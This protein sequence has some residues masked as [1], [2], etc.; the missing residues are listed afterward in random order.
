[1]GQGPSPDEGCHGESV[2][3]RLQCALVLDQSAFE[4]GVSSKHDVVQHDN[5]SDFIAGE[6][7]AHMAVDGFP[8]TLLNIHGSS[9]PLELKAGM[10]SGTL[11]AL[12]WA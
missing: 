11:D 5:G 6:V 2:W 12:R 3:C 8:V 4:V 10:L 1:M 9:S 7:K